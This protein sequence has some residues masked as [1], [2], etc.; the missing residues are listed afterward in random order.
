M[1]VTTRPNRKIL[2]KKSG[3][4]PVRAAFPPDKTLVERNLPDPY[5]AESMLIWGTVYDTIPR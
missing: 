3:V 4:T 1:R 5:L 2:P